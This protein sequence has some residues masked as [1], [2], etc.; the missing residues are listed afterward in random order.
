MLQM[1]IC[2]NRPGTYQEYIENIINIGEANRI[3]VTFILDQRGSQIKT[4]SA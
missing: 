2:K 3:D 4:L 1:D